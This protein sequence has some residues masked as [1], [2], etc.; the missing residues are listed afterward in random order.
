MTKAIK[1]LT[2]LPPPQRQRLMTLAHE[3]SFPEDSRIFEAGGTADR[4]WVVRSGAVS[5]TQ[6]VTSQQ[7]VTVAGLGSGDL[8]GWSWLF[9]PYR[10]DFGAEA[11]SPVRAYEFDAAAVLELCEEDPQLAVILVRSVAEILA[12]RLETTRGKLLE[13]YS[14]HR[15]SAL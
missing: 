10:W 9:P 7:R 8:L 6:Q 15:R 14:M 1:L 3:V 13:Q 5:L 12:H 11:F 4:F 2:A